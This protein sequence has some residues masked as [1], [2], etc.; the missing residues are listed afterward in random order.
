MFFGLFQVQ[1]NDSDFDLSGLGYLKLNHVPRSLICCTFE[2]RGSISEGF[3]PR[4]KVSES[5]L[6]S[7][8]EK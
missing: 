3:Q 8:F 1:R 5:Y 2:T 6:S 4:L 7:Y